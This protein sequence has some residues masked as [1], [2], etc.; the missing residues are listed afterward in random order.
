[1]IKRCG[2][3]RRRM[4]LRLEV[5]LEIRALRAYDNPLWG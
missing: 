2:K 5:E 1:M 4:L 3:W